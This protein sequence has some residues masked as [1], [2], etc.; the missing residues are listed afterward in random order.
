[1]QNFN[2]INGKYIICI[3]AKQLRISLAYRL[4]LCLKTENNWQDINVIY[5]Y[6]S[7]KPVPAPVSLLDPG[8]LARNVTH[9]VLIKWVQDHP[10]I[11]G[12]AS[13]KRGKAQTRLNGTD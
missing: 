2:S 9:Q 7:N 13:R 12:W 10:A 8:K 1:M 11:G 5:K 3:G 4:N 6:V